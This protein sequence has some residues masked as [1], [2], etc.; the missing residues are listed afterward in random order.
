MRDQF[1]PLL[2]ALLAM[3]LPALGHV[4]LRRWG[5]RCCGT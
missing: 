3:A 5:G 4:V 1:R 2:A